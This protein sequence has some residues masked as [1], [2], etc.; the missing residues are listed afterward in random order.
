M[1][2]ATH[3]HRRTAPT[4]QTPAPAPDTGLT[5]FGAHP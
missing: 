3:S 2:L 1:P 5:G 4:P